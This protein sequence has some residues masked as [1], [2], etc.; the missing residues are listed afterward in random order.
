[1]KGT[2]AL[3]AGLTA[4]FG[5]TG[6][7]NGRWDVVH[8]FGGENAGQVFGRHLLVLAA[9]PSVLATE[10]FEAGTWLVSEITGSINL[11]LGVQAG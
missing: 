10:Q 7:L 5:A 9:P 2:A 11:N 4:N 8:R 1:L 6:Q 3:G